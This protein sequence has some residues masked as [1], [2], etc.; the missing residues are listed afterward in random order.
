M[1]RKDIQKIADNLERKLHNRIFVRSKNADGNAMV[2]RSGNHKALISTG[3]LKNEF[4]VEATDSSIYISVPHTMETIDKL[5][6]KYGKIFSL[7]E[8]EKVFLEEEITKIVKNDI[9]RTNFNSK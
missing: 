2:K 3:K 5:E 1:D 6:T 8:E 9:E 4:A 7:T